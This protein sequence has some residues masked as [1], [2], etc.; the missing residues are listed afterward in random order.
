M[1]RRVV[2]LIYQNMKMKNAASKYIKINPDA[3]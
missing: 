3:V 2:D 1:L